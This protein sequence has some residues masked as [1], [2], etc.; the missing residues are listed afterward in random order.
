[1]KLLSITIEGFR[2]FKKAQAIRLDRRPGLYLIRGE[3]QVEPTLGANGSGKSSVWDAL[4]WVI[5]GKTTRKLSAAHVE[6]W[7]YRGP[8]CVTLTFESRT[9]KLRT[10]IRSRKPIQVQIDGVEVTQDV[11][12]S[13]FGLDYDMFMS[14]VVFSQM[15]ELFPDMSATRRLEVFTTVL[16][17]GQWVEFADKAKKESKGIEE[18]IN[19]QARVA[20]QLQGSLTAKVSQLESLIEDSKEVDIEALGRECFNASASLVDSKLRLEKAKKKY[21]AAS[22]I[23]EDFDRG[24]SALADD[25]ERVNNSIDATKIKLNQEEKLERTLEAD[26]I[27]LRDGD[28][29]CLECGASRPQNALDA[30]IRSMM[31]TQEEARVQYE[32]LTSMHQKALK[33]YDGL[34]EQFDEI[35]AKQG[36]Y[37]LVTRQMRDECKMLKAQRNHYDMAARVSEKLLTAA[38]EQAD[39]QGKRIVSVEAEIEAIKDSLKEGKEEQSALKDDQTIANYWKTGFR[40][41]R[42]WMVE[43]A[44]DQLSIQV[45]AALVSLGLQEWTISFS[46]ERETKAK[47]VSRG[48]EIIIRNPAHK[49]GVLWEA[50]SGGE[51][52]RLRVACAAG[53]SS[54]IRDR[55]Q[56]IPDVEVWDEPTQFL[57][58]GGV[59]DLVEYL[60]ERAQSD[61]R[62]VYLVDH[63]SLDSGEFDGIITVT[64]TQEGSQ[65]TV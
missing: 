2:S 39:N 8:T 4:T 40:D 7:D 48:F 17:L 28:G 16:G 24:L 10:L 60:K 19:N 61:N 30:A 57:G 56:G 3:N 58:K 11:L 20:S 50:W 23:D 47:T 31:D 35:E 62:Q 25:M 1:M 37:Q 34:C 59:D 26:F 5:Y 64:K 27:K 55:G 49:K 44:L 9:G 63:R 22:M 13:L 42:L 38:Q 32:K 21:E 29:A 33:R 18:K 15:P 54:L 45:N 53:L 51:T 14:T 41:L 46:V 65:V 6:A 43:N 36:K 52:Q 12:D